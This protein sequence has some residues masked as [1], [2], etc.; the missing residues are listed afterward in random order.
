ML[1]DVHLILLCISAAL[2]YSLIGGERR[3]PLPVPRM[4]VGKIR[5][6]E[7]LFLKVGEKTLDCG[8]KFQT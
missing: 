6:C 5:E 4:E 8:S 3:E 1:S 7:V 2:P